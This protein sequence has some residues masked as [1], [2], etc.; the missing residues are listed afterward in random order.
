MYPKIMKSNNL[1][2]AGLSD[3][4]RKTGQLWTTFDQLTKTVPIPNKVSDDGY[5][6]RIYEEECH[7]HVGYAVTN[8]DVNQS[9]KS[10]ILPASQYAVFDVHPIKGYDSEN[11]SMDQW[12]EENKGRFSQ[13]LLNGKPYVVEF[14]GERF[15]GNEVD[16]IVEIWIPIETTKYEVSDLGIE[17]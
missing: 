1:I 7:V 2:I 8:T 14:F 9:F 4:G 17:K 15:N 5:E 10:L 12:L 11:E 3:D 16:S 13:K 6:V